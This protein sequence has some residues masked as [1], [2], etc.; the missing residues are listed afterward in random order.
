MN[1][2][3]MRQAWKDRNKDIDKDCLCSKC[4]IAD[5]CEYA[6]DLYNFGDSCLGMK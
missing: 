5:I 4:E 6:F 1:K 3:D 2:E